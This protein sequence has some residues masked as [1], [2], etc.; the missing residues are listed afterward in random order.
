M[1]NPPR[2]H[3]LFYPPDAE[4][5]ASF[6]ASASKLAGNYS[7]SV[8]NNNSPSYENMHSDS[9]TILEG[10]GFTQIHNH[11]INNIKS[12]DAFLVWCYLY[13]KTSNWKTVKENIK[14]TYG[15]GDAKI[16]K[17]FAYLNRARL[18]EY[19]QG[20][21]DIGRYTHVQI[22]ILNGSK[23]DKTQA[24]I[25]SAPLRQKPIPP[26]KHTNENDGLLNKDITKERKTHN[27]GSNSAS[28]DAR[29][30]ENESFNNFWKIYPVKKNKIRAA[31]IWHRNKYHEISDTIIAD[32]SSRALTDAQWQD[33]QF[34]P[35][36]S[37][38]LANKLWLDEIT[39]ATPKAPN[40]GSNAGDSLS[41]V[42][43]KYMN[44]GATYD[45]H[46]NTIDPLRG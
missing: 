20:K 24:W 36:P 46:G 33:T 44:Q 9:K 29:V 32:V 39:Q 17:I 3:L 26:E 43:N 8:H 14:K 22:R 19:V 2:P 28:Q 10:N 35:H 37:T 31:R 40:K 21:S 6:T 15:F 16:K 34:I 23:F 38:Y 45:Q 11:V 5:L 30:L 4:D 12:G 42:L 13:S 25:D 7:M 1:P 18:I 27:T 41:R